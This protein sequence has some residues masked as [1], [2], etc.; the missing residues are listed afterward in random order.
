MCVEAEVFMF[1]ELQM[2]TYGNTTGAKFCFKYEHMTY[3]ELHYQNLQQRDPN[4]SSR[5]KKA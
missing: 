2:P 1:A 5:E 3:K 4:Y